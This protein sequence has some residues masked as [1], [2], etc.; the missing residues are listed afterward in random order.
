[1]EDEFGKFYS[2]QS[3]S[4]HSAQNKHSANQKQEPSAPV[5]LFAPIE[6]AGIPRKEYAWTLLLQKRLVFYLCPPQMVTRNPTDLCLQNDNQLS[7]LASD[8]I[9]Q[10]G[11]HPIIIIQQPTT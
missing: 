1:M 9:L 8:D 2:K 11:I 4:L 6:M 7:S 10:S 5:H 3:A